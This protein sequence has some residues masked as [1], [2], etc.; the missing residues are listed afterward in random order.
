MKP[1]RPLTDH[2]GFINRDMRPVG[3]IQRTDRS[4]LRVSVMADNAGIPCATVRLWRQGRDGLGAPA[5]GGGF[6][7]RRGELVELIELLYRALALL[8][9]REPRG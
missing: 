9:A 6:T 3:C 1:A 7:A 4:E 5:P 2:P 8:P